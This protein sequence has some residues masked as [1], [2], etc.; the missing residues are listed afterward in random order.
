MNVGL[1]YFI[2]PQAVYGSE[3]AKSVF[4]IS[5]NTRWVCIARNTEHIEHHLEPAEKQGRIALEIA[6]NRSTSDLA[7]PLQFKYSKGYNLTGIYH[8][9]GKQNLACG[10]F[11][12]LPT[13][14]LSSEPNP[15]QQH[16][17]CG[18]L[19][20]FDTRPTFARSLEMLVISNAR[21][22]VRSSLLKALENGELDGVLCDLKS[23]LQPQYE[24]GTDF[25]EVLRQANPMDDCL[26]P[27]FPISLFGLAA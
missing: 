20:R 23:E 7:S 2:R 1:Y 16:S 15:M 19:M 9:T 24:Y 14:G 11:N 6:P 4:G 25:Y 10:Q 27:G 22:Q 26:N 8:P 18:I 5:S 13:V 12:T 17:H 21:H 3:V